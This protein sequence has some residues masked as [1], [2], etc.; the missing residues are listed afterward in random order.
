[1]RIIKLLFLN[2]KRVDMPL[3]KERNHLPELPLNL[4]VVPLTL[5]LNLWP[6][7]SSVLIPYSSYTSHHPS[8]T[9]CLP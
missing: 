7:N 3:N 2:L 9:S 5:T 4:N 8:Q 6:I 1:M